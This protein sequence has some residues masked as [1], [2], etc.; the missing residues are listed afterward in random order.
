MSS[1][2]SKVLPCTVLSVKEEE[3]AVRPMTMIYINDK[4]IEG[5]FTMNAFVDYDTKPPLLKIEGLIKTK[6]RLPETFKVLAG[7]RIVCKSITITSESVGSEEE[8]IVSGFTAREY[9]ILTLD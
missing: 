9:D 6:L 2:L 3:K 7:G 4:L 8:E 1:V 5:S